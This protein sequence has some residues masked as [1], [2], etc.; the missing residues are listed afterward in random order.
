MTFLDQLGWIISP[1]PFSPYSDLDNISSINL[2][3]YSHAGVHNQQV[4]FPPL[5]NLWFNPLPPPTIYH[6][7]NLQDKSLTSVNV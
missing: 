2:V 1:T 7:K 3:L 6:Y 4:Q 5:I